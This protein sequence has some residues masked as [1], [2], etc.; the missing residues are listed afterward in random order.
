MQTTSRPFYASLAS[1]LL[2]SSSSAHHPRRLRNNLSKKSHH[3]FDAYISNVAKKLAKIILRAS[4]TTSAVLVLQLIYVVWKTPRLPPPPLSGVDFVREGRMVAPNQDGDL[5]DDSFVFDETKQLKEFRIVLIGDSPVEGIGNTHHRLALSGSTAKAFA[6]KVVTINNG[7]SFD[8]VRYWSYGKS[9]LTAREIED[10]MVPHLHRVQ[11]SLTGDNDDNDKQ[12]T[13]IHAIVLL[14]GVNNVLDVKSTSSSFHS[15]VL[16]LIRSIRNNR[17]LI[18]T[19]L[20]VLGLPDF[21]KLPFLPWPLAFVLGYRGRMMQRMLER[22]VREVQLQERE[23]NTN[24]KS[25]VRTLLKV[26]PDVQY[27]LGTIGYHRCDGE[28]STL[29]MRLCHPLLKYLG[30]IRL[31]QDKIASLRITDFLCDDGFH[32]GRLGTVYVGNLI[33]E[34]YEEMMMQ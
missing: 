25:N 22:A 33:R 28:E 32:P 20:I 16:S 30:G 6:Q 34:A 2:S 18:N 9:G 26:I 13:M 3:Y 12:H 1:L 4:I 5:V 17:H 19:P 24:N 27:V 29:Q 11:K 21:S 8:C 23:G 10:D 14:C 15:D 7:E 31:A